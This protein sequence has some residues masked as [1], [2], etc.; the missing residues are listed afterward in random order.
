MLLTFPSVKQAHNPS[1]PAGLTGSPQAVSVG[2][3]LLLGGQTPGK[4]VPCVGL[5]SPGCLL[6]HACF[7]ARLHPGTYPASWGVSLLLWTVTPGLCSFSENQA[8]GAITLVCCQRRGEIYRFA[9]TSVS[10]G[11]NP[12]AL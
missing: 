9:P 5:A 10:G 3:S 2:Y 7:A 11:F 12:D 4:E 6:S 1:G 8:I